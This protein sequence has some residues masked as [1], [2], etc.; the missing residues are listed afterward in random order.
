MALRELVLALERD[1]L[2]RITAVRD[3]A[4]N[5]AGRLRADARARLAHRRATD[6]ATRGTELSAAAAGAL[7][8]ARR[9][10]SARALTARAETL[11]AIRTRAREVLGSTLPEAELQPGIR[12]DLDAALAYLGAGGAVVRCSPGWTRTLKA[13]L[14]G[15]PEVPVESGEGMGAGMVVRAIDGSVEIDATVENRL[16]RLWSGIAIELLR[17]MEPPS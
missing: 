4:T 6:L 15:R 8:A 10:A 16:A 5:E 1:A 7:D 2:A 12:R 9:D 3:E 17:D 13:A 11:E 14:A